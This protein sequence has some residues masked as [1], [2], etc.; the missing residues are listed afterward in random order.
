MGL[1]ARENL[2]LPDGDIQNTKANQHAVIRAVRRYRPPVVLVTAERVRHPDHGAATALSVDALFYSG[3]AKVETFEDDGT[4]QEPWRP[5]HVL[6]YLQALD[7]EPTFVV[8]V[9]DVW[10]RRMQALL[11][12]KSQFFQGD[13]DGRRRA[14]D[15]H[16]EPPL[17]QV[18]R[19][20]GPDLRLPHRRRLRRAVRLPPRPRRRR[21]PGK[22]AV[23]GEAVPVGPRRPGR[24]PRPTGGGRPPARRAGGPRR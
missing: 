21:R 15:L 8:D 12:Y 1:A 16:L 13:A 20:P 11:S 2:G 4:A 17:P 5:H 18:G 24:E 23:A 19:G 7:A 10:E 9:S 3:L 6:H 22:G 14:G